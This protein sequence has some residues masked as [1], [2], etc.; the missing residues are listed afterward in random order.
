MKTYFTIGLIFLFAIS[1]AQDSKQEVKSRIKKVTVY[2]KG[3][4]VF[5]ESFLEIKPGTTIFSIPRLSAGI[6][7]QSIQAEIE[8]SK[9]KIISVGFA[10]NSIDEI[11]KSSAA[12]EYESQ[13][14][15]LHER[16]SQE[17]GLTEVFIQEEEM[18]KSNKS[19]GGQLAMLNII[20]S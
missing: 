19:I 3:A 11:K 1:K 8:D 17:K 7:E 14:K 10:V 2:L 12:I 9:A 4:H 20:F 13:L 6:L 15:T 18:L 5:R 16:L